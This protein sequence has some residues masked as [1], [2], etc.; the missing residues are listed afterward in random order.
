MRNGSAQVL[1]YPTMKPCAKKRSMQS[2]I[3]S[4]RKGS[5]QAK[6]ISAAESSSRGCCL[7]CRI[8]H[9]KTSSM[10]SKCSGPGEQ[11]ELCLPAMG[12]DCWND[13][14][15]ARKYDIPSS[16]SQVSGLTRYCQIIRHNCK[17]CMM[18]LIIELRG[19]KI[20]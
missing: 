12:R 13:H 15:A 18:L 7:K 1:H 5:H 2:T 17:K 4:P 8:C 14:H 11:L 10:C 6:R 3:A 20:H 16:Q 9:K 19:I